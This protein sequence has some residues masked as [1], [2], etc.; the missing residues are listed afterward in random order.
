MSHW[1]AE[2]NSGIADRQIRNRE[3]LGR[4][5]DAQHRGSKN[6]ER[7][8]VATWSMTVTN[9]LIV[10]GPGRYRSWFCICLA[11]QLVATWSMT[12]TN[13]LIV[14]GPGRYRSWFC[15]CLALQLVATS[16]T[17]TNELIVTG[18]GRYRSWFCICLALQLVATLALS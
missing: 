18:P 1:L 9:E 15:I 7:G 3:R 17:V 8:A 14:T 12:V 6:A 5:R 10:T 4:F 11:L 13:E 16:V 2:Q